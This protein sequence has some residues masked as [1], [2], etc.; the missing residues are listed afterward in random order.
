MWDN[1]GNI[2]SQVKNAAIAAGG[3]GPTQVQVL[4]A[5]GSRSYE[6]ARSVTLSLPGVFVPA[7]P[8]HCPVGYS[9][10]SPLLGGVPNLCYKQVPSV[11]VCPSGQWIDHGFCTKTIMSYDEMKTRSG[12]ATKIKNVDPLNAGYF[13]FDGNLYYRGSP[14]NLTC[15]N[16]YSLVGIVCRQS[17]PIIPL[18]AAHCQK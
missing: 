16:G 7:V 18:V 5:V 15:P 17:V 1:N 9:A 6:V 2:V 4:A 10:I 12:N 11:A 8:A 13:T 14:P 3:C